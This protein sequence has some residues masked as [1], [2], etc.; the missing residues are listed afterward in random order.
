LIFT[1]SRDGDAWKKA[2]LA[3]LAKLG[4]RAWL[5]CDGCRHSIMIEPHELAQ[6]H[7][8]DMLTPLLTISK[9]MCCTR[10]GARMGCCWPEPHN[11][12]AGE[13]C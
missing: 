4:K 11:T 8:L 2:H 1:Q 3:M 12:R 9:A 7:R 6:G 5:H 10:C 13:R